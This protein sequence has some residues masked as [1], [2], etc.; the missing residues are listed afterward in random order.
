M[1]PFDINNSYL[2]IF[3]VIINLN[4]LT[5]KIEIFKFHILNNKKSEFLGSVPS[6][7]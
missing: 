7:H 2:S 4:N 3:T 1:I 5:N 6:M